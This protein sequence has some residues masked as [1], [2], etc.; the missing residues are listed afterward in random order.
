M[1]WAAGPLELRGLMGSELSEEIFSYYERLERV[2]RFVLAHYTE[3]IT[4]A[5][6]CNKPAETT[7]LSR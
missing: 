7:E 1:E 5:V 2:R 4:L 3:P 6:R